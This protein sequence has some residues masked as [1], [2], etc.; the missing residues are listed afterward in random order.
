MTDKKLSFYLVDATLP[1]EVTIY[2][3]NDFFRKLH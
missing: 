1:Y 3:E 2:H